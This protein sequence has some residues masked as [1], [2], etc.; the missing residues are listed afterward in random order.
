MPVLQSFAKVNLGLWV[1]GRRPDGFHEVF[2]PI[3]KVSLADLVEVSPSDRLEV[4]TTFPIPQ[5]ENLVYRGLR[6]FE[7]R[8]GILQR[9]KI[10]IEK[11]VPV[12]GGLGGG[13]SN[14]ATVLKFVNDYYGSPLSERE[15]S[16][17]VAS[18]SSD[19]PSFLCDGVAVA[20]GRG[21]RVS[22]L[23]R[24]D[25]R[26]VP[27]TLF[28]PEGVSSPT[29]EVYR[30]LDPSAFVSPERVR[31]LKELLK[32]APLEEF[33][34]RAENALGEVFL[35]LH[36]SV[37][38]DVDFLRKVCYKKFLVSGSG[39]SFFTVGSLDRRCLE[40]VDRLKNRYKI[41][42]LVTL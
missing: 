12:G 27:I 23:R 20:E 3:V 22:C 32:S 37:G 21:E 9:W 8:T 13:S 2:T 5:E 31:P 18:L 26:G 38:R 15:L 1:L 4:R 14:L 7:E 30:A 42:F 35:R 29:G 10:F 28:V 40:A 36:P 24:P 11:K 6:L 39:S 17:L 41:F 34:E 19:A 33:F 25:Y 16:E